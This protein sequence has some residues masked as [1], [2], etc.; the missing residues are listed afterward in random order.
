MK[1][2]Q[3]KVKRCNENEGKVKPVHA[4]HVYRK[5]EV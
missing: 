4:I 1:T 2:Y 3:I 5:M